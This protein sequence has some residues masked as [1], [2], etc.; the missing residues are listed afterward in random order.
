MQL[1]NAPSLGTLNHGI[2]LR[3]AATKLQSQAAILFD[4]GCEQGKKEV[5]PFWQFQKEQVNVPAGHPSDGPMLQGGVVD[6]RR[7]CYNVLSSIRLQGNKEADV[8][9][10]NKFCDYFI[11]S[12]YSL[13]DNRSVVDSLRVTVVYPKG[14]TSYEWTDNTVQF[15]VV[16]LDATGKEISASQDNPLLGTL[17]WMLVNEGAIAQQG[18]WRGQSLKVTSTPLE[19][20]VGSVS[21]RTAGTN[22]AKYKYTYLDKSVIGEV[23]YVREAAVETPTAKVADEGTNGV[24]I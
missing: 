9:A 14:R 6:I 1:H 11:Q 2:K 20:S 21:T 15:L 10:W 18:K 19:H 4:M 16:G 17:D 7:E 3:M 22:T 5:V 13:D 23:D 24:V 12:A 8:E